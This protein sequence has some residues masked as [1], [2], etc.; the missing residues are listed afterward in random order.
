MA[1]DQANAWKARRKVKQNQL[2]MLLHS[3]ADPLSLEHYMKHMY[4]ELEL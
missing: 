3:C 2:F 1:G 4:Y